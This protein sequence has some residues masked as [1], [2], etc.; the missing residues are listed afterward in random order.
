MDSQKVSN[1][2]SF[3]DQA[4]DLVRNAMQTDPNKRPSASELSELPIFKPIVKKTGKP[5]KKEPEN[6]DMFIQISETDDMFFSGL[7]LRESKA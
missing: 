3:Y 1:T 6:N 4:K 5:L 7:S 2:C